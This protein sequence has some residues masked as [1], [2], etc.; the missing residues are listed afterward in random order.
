MIRFQINRATVDKTQLFKQILHDLVIFVGVYA[1]MR[2]LLQGPADAALTDALIRAVAGNAVDHTVRAVVQPCSAC[3]SRICRFNVLS[4]G[5]EE[6]PDDPA[7]I[8]QRGDKW[9][10]SINCPTT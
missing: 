2:T 3:N 5:E 9:F 10:V 8:G 7:L 1:Q 6:R 4:E